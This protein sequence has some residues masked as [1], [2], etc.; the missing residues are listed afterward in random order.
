M[1]I[2]VHQ[3][4]ANDSSLIWQLTNQMLIHV[5]KEIQNIVDY[6]FVEGANPQ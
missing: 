5:K 2:I 4:W 6:F 3:L 1:Y